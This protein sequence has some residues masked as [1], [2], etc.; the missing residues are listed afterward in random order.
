[1]WEFKSKYWISEKQTIK[2]NVDWVWSYI[3][4]KCSPGIQGNIEG[5]EDYNTELEDMDIVW[6]MEEVNKQHIWVDTEAIKETT[7]YH[8][9][10]KWLNM[11]K[12]PSESDTDFNSS[13]EDA[14]K[15]F[16][17][18]GGSYKFY[19]QQITKKLIIGANKVSDEKIRSAIEKF[20]VSSYLQQAEP[21][22]YGTIRK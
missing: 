8:A 9:M 4:G 12:I 10:K 17:F 5:L 16:E 21:I 14:H 7:L 1:M 13:F 6:L 22:R 15:D 20:K 11:K 2:D 3:W 19:I 18:A